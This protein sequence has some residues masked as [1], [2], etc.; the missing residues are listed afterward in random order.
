MTPRRSWRCLWLLLTLAYFCVVSPAM[1]VTTWVEETAQMRQADPAIIPTIT[2]APGTDLFGPHADATRAIA[3]RVGSAPQ[4]HVIAAGE[5]DW[6]KLS[7]ADGTGYIRVG[8]AGDVRLSLVQPDGQLGELGELFGTSEGTD[9]SEV[10]IL[11]DIASAA[12]QGLDGVYFVVETTS[13]EAV[14]YR[15]SYVNQLPDDLL[16]GDTPRE[17][18]EQYLR[19]LLGGDLVAVHVDSA[20]A[21]TADQA[22][23][24]RQR[25]FGR[26]EPVTG[27]ITLH[28]SPGH[29]ANAEFDAPQQHVIVSHMDRPD[30]IWS[31]AFVVTCCQRDGWWVVTDVRR[32]PDL[33]NQEVAQVVRFD[34]DTMGVTTEE[35]QRAG[36]SVPWAALVVGGL[37]AALV[38]VGVLVARRLVAARR[39]GSA[40]AA[41]LVAVFGGTTEW[42]GKAIFFD[43]VR[44][45][46]EGHGV[47][48][49]AD[50]MRYD[51]QGLLE[52]PNEG[53]RAW[54]GAKAA[55]APK[56]AA[57]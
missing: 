19:G 27:E 2:G 30:D 33:T 47:I 16:G 17:A 3:L 41:R 1:A 18:T 13:T 51:G 32:D 44:F 56:T 48:A 39:S 10:R 38:A 5:Q 21:C 40:E 9:L 12:D 57:T 53:M 34:Y 23:A 35:T 28:E 45:V 54:V 52:W 36:G 25:A 49:A 37:V 22:A 7:T 11:P 4:D 42:A 26:R 50:V 24:A 14:V 43:G 55:S 8:S 20:V 46:L 29:S 31:W 6:F 15:I